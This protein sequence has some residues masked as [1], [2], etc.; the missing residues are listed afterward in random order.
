MSYEQTLAI[1]RLIAHACVEVASQAETSIMFTAYLSE[2]IAE[3]ARSCG[4]VEYPSL[5]T[6][7]LH[8]RSARLCTRRVRLIANQIAVAREAGQA[9]R[10]ASSQIAE[11]GSRTEPSLQALKN[12]VT[13]AIRG[14]ARA[15]R[16]ARIARGYLW[17]SIDIAFDAA[18]DRDLATLLVQ[19]ERSS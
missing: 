4:N 18:Q 5:H 10:L 13:D 1:S 16:A 3:S 17:Q 14:A 12:A 2:R 11:L 6:R 19:G 15:E 7:C 9:A 8:A